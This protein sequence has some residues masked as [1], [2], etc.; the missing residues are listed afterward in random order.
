MS[1]E[2]KNIIDTPLPEMLESKFLEYAEETI[3][4]RALPKIQDG[5]KPAQ[6][7]TL[8]AMKDMGLSHAAMHRKCAKVVGHVIGTY[9]P[10]GDI[11]AYD[12]LVGLAQ[13]WTKRY[14]LID[15]HGK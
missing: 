13:P 8:W 14:P 12:A 1:E 15:F 11:S 4:D 10:H 2:L 6:R 5:L 3:V 7:Y 9:H